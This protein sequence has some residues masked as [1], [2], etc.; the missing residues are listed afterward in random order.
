MTEEKP[1][2]LSDNISWSAIIVVLLFCIASFAAGYG[3]AVKSGA[4]DAADIVAEF[5]EANSCV[6]RAKQMPMND[7]NFSNL[8]FT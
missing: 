2:R 4:N 3:L 8:N 5:Q 7:L 1:K 6:Y